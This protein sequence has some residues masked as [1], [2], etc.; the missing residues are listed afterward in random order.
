MNTPMDFAKQAKMR[1]YIALLDQAIAMAED[2][3][4]QINDMGRLLEERF[5]EAKAA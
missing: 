4:C 3:E 5:P 2:L 1:A